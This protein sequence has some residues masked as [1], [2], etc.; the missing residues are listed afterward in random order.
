M[1]R[2]VAA[3][4]VVCQIPQRHGRVVVVIEI[5]GQSLNESNLAAAAIILL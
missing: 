3:A 2:V 4:V 1:V 5:N